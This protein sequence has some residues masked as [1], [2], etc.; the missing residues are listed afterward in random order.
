MGLLPSFRIEFAGLL[1]ISNMQIWSI[2]F[3][4]PTRLSPSS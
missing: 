1:K 4:R 3:Y 2:I